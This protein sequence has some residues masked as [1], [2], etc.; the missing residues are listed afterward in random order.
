LKIVK[1]RLID[2]LQRTAGYDEVYDDEYYTNIVD[3]FMANSCE[4]IAES[5]VEAFS[6]E[7]VV[8]VGCGTGLLLLALKK[9]G[10]NR[11]FGID[12]AKR[13]VEICEKRGLDVIRLDLEHETPPAYIKSDVVI[14]T[15]VAE[16][17]PE[18]SAEQFV[19]ILCSISGNVV[20]T[21]CPPGPNSALGR[22]I[23]PNE[24]PKEYWIKKFE[25]RGFTYD[26]DISTKWA[27]YWRSCKVTGNYS[28][29]LMVFRKTEKN[30]TGESI[31]A[32]N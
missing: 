23:H 12:Y 25:S 5:I 21:A 29:G 3:P 7:S 14:S 32:E 2:L 27:T 10:V 17:L 28:N 24:R 4:T 18:T 20:L 26:Q 16:H 11:T 30:F 9:K 19:D 15:E 1:S 13:A 22:Y 6:P 8:D 31:P